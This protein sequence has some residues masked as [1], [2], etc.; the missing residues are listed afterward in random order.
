MAVRAVIGFEKQRAVDVRQFTRSQ[1]AAARVDPANEHRARCG[2]VALPQL[3]GCI[4]IVID[5]E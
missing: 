5:E 3:L 4:S 2:A 1:V